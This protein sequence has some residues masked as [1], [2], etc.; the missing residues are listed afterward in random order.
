MSVLDNFKRIAAIPR[1]SGHEEGI[2]AFIVGWA[3]SKGFECVTD[4]TGNVIIYCPATKG[5]ENVPEV[6]LQGH[7]DMVCVKRPGSK[8]DFRKDPIELVQDGDILRA[9]DTS[10]GADDGMAIATIMDIFTDPNAKHGKLEAICT[11]NEE[12]GLTGA[13]GLDAS[14]IHARKLIN[15]DSEEEGV[16]YVGC[17]GGS[18]VK[19]VFDKP[20]KPMCSCQEAV[21]LEISGLKSGHSG[22]EIHLQRANAIKVASRMMHQMGKSHDYSL[23]SFDGG[24]KRNAI[25][26]EACVVFTAK[27]EDVPAIKKELESYKKALISENRIEEPGMKITISA[28]DGQPSVYSKEDSRAFI[29]S[30]FMAP[31]G[32]LAWSKTI[33]G[34]VQTSCN[35]AIVRTEGNSITVETSQRSNVMSQRDAASERMAMILATSGA[36]TTIGEGYPAWDPDPNSKLAQFCA[37]AW[38]DEFGKKPVVTAIHAGLEC[39]IINSKIPGMDSVSIGPDLKDV[40]TVNESCSIS[41][42]ERISDFVKHLLSIIK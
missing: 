8:H 16:I 32:V 24:T 5:Y 18:D 17:A 23:A 30:L 42:A 34:I 13:Y 25:P 20:K 26:A 14:L 7:M 38:E 39:G 2:R 33:Q 27:K 28:V 9:K 3:A 6:A 29:N 40:H 10:L 37:K 12:V 22:G 21:S 19:A 41:S 31:H 1:E 4:K 15:I 35:L 36:T 11:V